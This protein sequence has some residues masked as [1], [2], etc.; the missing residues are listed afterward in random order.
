MERTFSRF[1]EQLAVQCV[2]AA[3]A[4]Q[5]GVGIRPSRFRE[6]MLLHR[7]LDK[8]DNLESLQFRDVCATTADKVCSEEVSRQYYVMAERS[9]DA[10][11]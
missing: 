6:R 9:I 2:Q 1:T 7:W 10:G 8:L 5:D 4:Q 3:D 11:N